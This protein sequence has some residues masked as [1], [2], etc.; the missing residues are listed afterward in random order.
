VLA[1]GDCIKTTK[2]R[3]TSVVAR[4]AVSAIKLVL[5]KKVPITVCSWLRVDRFLYRKRE[6]SAFGFLPAD[7]SDEHR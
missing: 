4:D 2:E 3:R 6:L 7:C 1:T 5:A